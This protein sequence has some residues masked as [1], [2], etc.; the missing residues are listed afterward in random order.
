[1]NV[2][3]SPIEEEGGGKR[4][5]EKEKRRTPLYTSDFI[6]PSLHPVIISRKRPSPKKE[7]NPPKNHDPTAQSIPAAAVPSLR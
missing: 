3:F 4:E 2:A 6:P 1:M 5:K 7:K